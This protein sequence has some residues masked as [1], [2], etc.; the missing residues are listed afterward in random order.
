MT[1]PRTISIANYDYPLPDSR[2]AAFPAEKRD[3]SKLLIWKNGNIS[4][5]A[6]RNIA[7]FLP[8]HS[9]LILNNTRVVEARLIFKKPTGAKIEIFCL[10]PGDQYHDITTAL[11]QQ[12]SVV[13]KCMV[14]RASSWQHQTVLE[15]K[16]DNEKTLYAKIISKHSDHFL[17]QLS[18]TPEDLFFSELLHIAGSTP[19]PPYIKRKPDASDTERYQT[20]YAEQPGSVAAPTA[21]L[22]FTPSVLQQLADSSIETAYVTLHVG[23]GTFKPVKSDDMS[24]HEMHAE[25]IEVPASLIE[26]ILSY[27]GSPIIAVGTTSLRTLESIYWIGVKL[28][29][30][31]HDDD[32]H[33]GQWEPYDSDTSIATRQ[34]L[35]AVL[36]YMKK[37]N[38]TTL[39][40][41]TSLMIAPSYIFRIVDILITNFHQP[42]STLL[43]LVA[44]FIG[45]KWKSAYAY[46][47][48]NDFR[49]L[50]YGD[51]CLLFRK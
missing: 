48:D 34:A 24:Q 21:G 36:L 11:A 15:K 5:D 45:E 47:L 29:R 9:L 50:S 41:K 10:E 27:S 40:T 51:S 32:L 16:I 8:Q 44:A 14:G 25:F 20:V 7:H 22:H 33:V 42:R 12:K 26:K 46:A 2:I 4:Q 38:I 28:L 6:F 35:E 49:F 43:L 31:I 18:W 3:D 39:I 1:D 17:I 13:W 23:A 37:K 30:N 19:L